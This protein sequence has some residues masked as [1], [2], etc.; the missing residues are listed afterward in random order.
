MAILALSRRRSLIATMTATFT[1]AMSS[2]VF[3][4]FMNAPALP[5]AGAGTTI[6]VTIS[7]GPNAVLPTSRKNSSMGI[8]LLAVHPGDRLTC[9][10]KRVE[11]RRHV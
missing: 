2:E 6:S 5:A 1:L 11:R 9:A 7:W 8:S 3:A 4:S 10:P